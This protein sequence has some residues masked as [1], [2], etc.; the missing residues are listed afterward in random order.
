LQTHTDVQMDE[1]N[2]Q[3][4]IEEQLLLSTVYAYTL[5]AMD[6]KDKEDEDSDVLLIEY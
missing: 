6:D 1:K 5:A 3:R 4:Y 2:G